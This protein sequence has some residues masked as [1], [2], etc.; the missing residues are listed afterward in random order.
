[1]VHNLDKHNHSHITYSNTYY[2]IQKRGLKITLNIYEKVATQP[3]RKSLK[4]GRA[5]Y[6]HIN[7]R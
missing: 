6:I 4:K 1:M 2:I 5:A 3:I 7:H